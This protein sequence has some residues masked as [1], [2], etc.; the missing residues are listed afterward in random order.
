MPIALP[1]Q[2]AIRLTA[3][4]RER[5]GGMLKSI[6]FGLTV[7]EMSAVMGALG[8]TDAVLLDGGISA[9]LVAGTGRLR[10]MMEGWRN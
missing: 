8:A 4:D 9:Q 10:I 3:A 6:P 7:P 5:L 2:I 1:E